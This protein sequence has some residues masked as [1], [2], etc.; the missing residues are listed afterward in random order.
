MTKFLIFLFPAMIDMVIGIT[1]FVGAVRMAENGGGPIA[2][3]MVASAWAIV[4]IA[5][6]RAVGKITNPATSPRLIIAGCTLI[7]LAALAFI[8]YPNLNATYPI[9]MLQALGSALF[10]VPF[11]VF[12]KAVDQGDETA[13]PRSVGLYTFAWSSG[14]AIGPFISAIIWQRQ[15]WAAC[16]I[17]AIALCAATAVGILFLKHHAEVKTA[18]ETKIKSAN[19][20]T[21]D[22]SNMPDLAWLGWLCAGLGCLAI[23]LLKSYLPSSASVMGISRLDQGILFALISGTQALTG[24]V[25]SR[26]SIWMYKALPIFLFGIC[27]VVALFIF[28]FSNSF[29]PLA[30]AS[31]LF[32]IYSGSFF[33]YLVFH[34]LVHPEHS[35]HYVSINES[36]VG[37]AVLFGPLLAG[38]IAAGFS[39]TTPYR[40]AALLILAT[41]L[42]QTIVTRKKMREA[43]N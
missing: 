8:L 42:F 37:G 14:M 1:A 32:G 5:C 20:P 11:Q 16:H 6:V 24:L 21:Y 13:L 4:Y 31:T 17:L 23:A 25:L 10:F 19:R 18:S 7:A 27:G 30:M 35:T 2:V 36:I 34:S 43:Q 26:S 38:F 39:I 33:F 28:S 9:M 29:I 41:I 22:Y 15:G 3:T 12:M 40:A